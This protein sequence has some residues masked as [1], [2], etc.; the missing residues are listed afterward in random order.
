MAGLTFYDI[1]IPLFTKSLKSLENILAKAEEHAAANGVSADSYVSEKLTE[2]M[3]PLSFQVQ[4]VSNT[5]KK[6]IWRLTGVENEAWEDNETTMGQLKTRVQKTLDLVATV[7]AKAVNGREN[8]VVE[9]QLGRAGS[10][11]LPAKD[12][13]FNYGIPNM[14]FHLQTAYAILR[15]KGVPLGKSDY[16]GAFLALKGDA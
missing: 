6:S 15:M 13:L 4:V 12:Y 5:I 10:M 7:D 3:F 11:N 1:S 9:L 2:N 14:F 8:V 16:L